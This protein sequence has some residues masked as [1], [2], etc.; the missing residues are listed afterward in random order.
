[1][2]LPWFTRTVVRSMKGVSNCSDSSKARLVKS[3]HSWLSAG[4]SMGIFMWGA[5]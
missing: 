4:S 3:L 5:K 2:L 1:M